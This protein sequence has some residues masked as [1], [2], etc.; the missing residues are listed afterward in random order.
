LIVTDERGRKMA[1]SRN[2]ITGLDNDLNT[3]GVI[4]ER[5]NSLFAIATR[6]SDNFVADADKET[7]KRKSDKI[8]AINNEIERRKSAFEDI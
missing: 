7:E 8:T 3:K 1:D 4:V 5:Y 2:S 6:S